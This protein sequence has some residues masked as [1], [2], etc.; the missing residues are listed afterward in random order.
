MQETQRGLME[1]TP[2]SAVDERNEAPSIR[3][4]APRRGGVEPGF[5]LSSS[6]Q[7]RS[8]GQGEIARGGDLKSTNRGDAR[9][10]HRNEVSTFGVAA[11][12]RDV[13]FSRGADRGA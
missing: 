2:V 13:L 12:K 11:Q 3:E 5:V 4:R 9:G 1:P 10:A 8:S 6:L 7:G